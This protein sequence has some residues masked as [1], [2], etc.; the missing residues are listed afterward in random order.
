MLAHEGQ[1]MSLRKGLQQEEA[2]P[3]V[4][5]E[6]QQRRTSMSA[7]NAFNSLKRNRCDMK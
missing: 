6:V 1:T 4:W 5:M 7:Q 2:H 3:F